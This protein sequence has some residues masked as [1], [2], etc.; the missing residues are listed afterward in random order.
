[1]NWH[2]ENE[3]KRILKYILRASS[4]EIMELLL[5]FDDNVS[6]RWHIDDWRTKDENCNIMYIAKPQL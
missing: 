3:K 2:F 1:M 5:Y 4:Y 6:R